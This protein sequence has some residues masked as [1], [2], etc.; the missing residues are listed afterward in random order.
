MHSKISSVDAA[1]K[2]V[3]WRAMREE[4]L[5]GLCDIDVYMK[6]DNDELF[7]S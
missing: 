2:S 1:V 6:Y 5:S 4:V 3:N 7:Q